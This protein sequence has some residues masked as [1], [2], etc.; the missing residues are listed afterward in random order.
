MILI[1]IAVPKW[2]IQLLTVY[3]Y[4]ILKTQVTHITSNSKITRKNIHNVNLTTQHKSLP[5]CGIEHSSTIYTLVP[6]SVTIN[7]V[8]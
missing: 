7:A 6:L 2:H 8:S 3:R 5:M 1:R 4:K